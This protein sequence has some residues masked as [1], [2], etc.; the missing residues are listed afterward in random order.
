MV[1][2]AA[3]SDSD[4]A[5]VYEVEFYLSGGSLS[6]ALIAT[7]TPTMYGWVATW[8]STTVPDGTYTLQSEAFDPVGN[9]GVGPAITVTVAN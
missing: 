4:S 3:A 7:A 8:D 6:D 2:D 1:L 5:G 9:V